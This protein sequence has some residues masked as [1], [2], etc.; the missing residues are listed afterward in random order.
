MYATQSKRMP[1]SFVARSHQVC[2]VIAGAVRPSF[3]KLRFAARTPDRCIAFITGPL[4]CDQLLLSSVK[5]ALMTNVGY[6][7]LESLDVSHPVAQYLLTAVKA[8]EVAVGSGSS[9]FVLVLSAIMGT[10]CI[11]IIILLTGYA[12][13]GSI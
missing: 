9:A 12:C 7:I 13:H 1:V 2:S 6:N 5:S 8:H 10:C 4:G 3:G 11:V